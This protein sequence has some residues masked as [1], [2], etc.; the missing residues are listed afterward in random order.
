MP[1]ASSYLEG[2]DY[3]V[4]KR[5]P[6]KLNVNDIA[7]TLAT[8]SA[9][10]NMGAERVKSKY[11][12]AMQ[13]DVTNPENQKLLKDYVS[14]SEGMIKSLA[15]QDLGN[16]DVQ[17][18]GIG[19]FKN[20]FNDEG[21]VY[22]DQLTR[23]HKKVRQDYAAMLKKD[24]SKAS[25]M[26]L[27]YALQDEEAF[28]NNPDRN[29]A[30]DYYQK[31][32]EY[33]PFYDATLDI[34]K[35]MKHCKASSANS[36]SP[37]QG[38]GYAQKVEDKSLSEERINSCFKAGLSG[39]AR[40]QF[41][42]TGYMAFKN[43]PEL[44]AT[45]YAYN[46]TL[47][48]KRLNSDLMDISVE[49]ATLLNKQKLKTITPAEAEQLKNI[50]AMA[51]SLKSEIKN[52]SDINGRIG[53]G[54]FSDL[55]KD[56][57]NIAGAVYTQSKISEFGKGFSFRDFSQKIVDDPVGTLKIRQQFEANQETNRQN[58]ELE[59]QR[60][61]ITADFVLEQLKNDRETA[62]KTE[63]EEEKAAK[64]AAK[65][66]LTE[67]YAGLVRN[68]VTEEL[69][70][71]GTLLPAS[72]IETPDGDIGS[73]TEFQKEVTGTKEAIVAQDKYLAQRIL[74]RDPTFLTTVGALPIPSGI[75]DKQ[76]NGIKY[77][78][79]LQKIKSGEINVDLQ[80][81]QGL[82]DYL[83]KNAAGN[84]DYATWLDTNLALQFKKGVI[85]QKSKR[86]ETQIPN[87]IKN[88]AENPKIQQILSTNITTGNGLVEIKPT[89]MQAALEGRTSNGLSVKTITAMGQSSDVLMYNGKE[90]L[91]KDYVSLYHMWVQVKINDTE[92]IEKLKEER[93]KLYSDQGWKHGNYFS[94]G[95]DE[96]TSNYVTMEAQL[97][98][99]IADDETKKKVQVMGTT[100]RGG[101][102]VYIPGFGSDNIDA[103]RQRIGGIAS[104]PSGDKIQITKSAEDGI[105]FIEG[106]EA[107]DYSKALG[108]SKPMLD[109]GVHLKS[110]GSTLAVGE[111]QKLP[112]PL[113]YQ[114][115]L[116]NMHVE[117]V[118]TPGGPSYRLIDNNDK[119][120]QVQNDPFV[121]MKNASDLQKNLK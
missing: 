30:K 50:T 101:I 40:Q 89:D 43:Q 3:Q 70:V 33:T 94:L 47:G 11:M 82:V 39:Q 100:F 31:R 23:H 106:L 28:R 17:Q 65:V 81:F 103:I 99:L 84:P 14:K 6:Y 115:T 75:I 76:Y 79:L 7:R 107:F 34:D 74:K 22:D 13:L 60:R 56:F 1:L 102:Q 77:A 86:L 63:T 85:D 20:L 93:S 66:K 48:I 52:Y 49:Q 38:S 29:A 54:D 118:Q 91:G 57:E 18:E 108:I 96:K 98:S 120:Y 92:R 2:N 117:I 95:I 113:I 8:K 10:W 58:F 69:E 87:G 26:N 21:I 116:S 5:S 4:L 53:K 19:I 62:K 72:N 16:P 67:N 114:G 41:N 104:T 59:K 111:S 44:L 12:E 119:V 109:M 27:G 73:Y 15:S 78:D 25:T 55:N 80:K 36:Q 121:I 61:D 64:A 83:N 42:I 24:P 105:F 46:N 45:E 35:I 97:A 71:Q 37:I 32:R 88:G 68:P 9:Y 51:D 112:L 110:I 90:V